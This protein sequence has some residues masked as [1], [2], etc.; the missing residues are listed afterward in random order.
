MTIIEVMFAIVIL[1]GVMLAL[2]RFGQ[3]FTRATRTAATLSLASDLAMARLEVIRA[4]PVYAQLD[5]FA[6]TE[7]G[8]DAGA[9]PSMAGYEGFTRTTTVSHSADPDFRTVTVTVTSPRLP[10]PVAKTAV[11]AVY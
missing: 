2:S 4:H 3:G 1:A 10:S 9:Y 5:G 8:G 11:I 7:V 6:A